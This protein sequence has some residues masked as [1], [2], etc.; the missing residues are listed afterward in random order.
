MNVH[1]R[2]QSLTV[3]LTQRIELFTSGLCAGVV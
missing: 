1:S 3:F 2:P